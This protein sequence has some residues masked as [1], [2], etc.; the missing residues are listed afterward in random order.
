M[1]YK[2]HIAFA[3]SCAIPVSYMAFDN[4]QDVV[5]FLALATIGSLSPDLDEEGSYLSN[6]FPIFPIVFKLFGVTH[7]GLTHRAMFVAFLG[8]LFSIFYFFYDSSSEYVPLYAGFL[9]GY[10]F[11]LLGDM[12]TKGGINRFFYPFSLRQAVLL[13]RKYRFYTGSIQEYLILVVF[14][15]IASFEFY[16]LYG[17]RF[18]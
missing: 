10:I 6:K 12:L 2:T 4:Y 3:L 1:T 16:H 8:V 17:E 14:V 11:H 7:R 18:L 9:F 5:S 15:A 13:P